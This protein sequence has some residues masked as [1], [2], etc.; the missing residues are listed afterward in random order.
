[1][2]SCKTVCGSTIPGGHTRV[3]VFPNKLERCASHENP[4]AA[5]QHVRKHGRKRDAVILESKL[6]G[7]PLL[8][9]ISMKLLEVGSILF[10]FFY[11]LIVLSF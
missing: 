10:V 8:I 9:C 3:T 2:L 4:S 1:M 6:S 7:F 5:E 11:S